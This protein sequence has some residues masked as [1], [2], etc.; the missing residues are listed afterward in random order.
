M[1]SFSVKHQNYQ[2]VQQ[3]ENIRLRTE[4]AE[5]Q[6][7]VT[8]Q[9]MELAMLR[10]SLT[11]EVERTGNALSKLEVCESLRMQLEA[12]LAEG[13]QEIS[14]LELALEE[15]KGHSF[16]DDEHDGASV[17]GLQALVNQLLKENSELRSYFPPSSLHAPSTEPG[18]GS[19]EA[20]NLVTS[21]YSSTI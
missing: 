20:H 7:R 18:S 9:D 13:Q 3:K 6:R 19:E 8:S 2:P 11:V 5:C 10:S 17:I 15:S 16:R 14:D 1:K 21:G 12:Q 4:L